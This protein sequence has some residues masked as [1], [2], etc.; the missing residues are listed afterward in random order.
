[1][2]AACLK[3]TPQY[4]EIALE[5]TRRLGTKV[6]LSQVHFARMEGIQHLAIRYSIGEVLDLRIVSLQQL[7]KPT[8]ELQPAQ[9]TRFEATDTHGSACNC[10]VPL[11]DHSDT[12]TETSFLHAG[13]IMFDFSVM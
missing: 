5:F 3:R 6:D 10:V 7:V 11:Q 4:A 12:C 9:A 13:L 8:E 1:M 2:D